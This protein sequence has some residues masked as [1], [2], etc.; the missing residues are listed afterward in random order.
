[1]IAGIDVSK[2]WID[3]SLDGTPARRFAH[4]PQGLAGLVRHARGAEL[5]AMEA[6]GRYHRAAARALRAAGMPVAVL[7]PAQ[8][9]RYGQALGTRSKTDPGDARL[10]ALFAARNPLR[11]EPEPDPAR[12]RL[13]ALVRTRSRQVRA[14]AGLRGSLRAP[15]LDAYERQAM[16]L[17]L[18]F[19]EAQVRLSEQQIRAHLRANEALEGQARLLRTVPGVGE[20]TAWCVLAEFEAARFA[21]AKAA[22]AFAG[23]CPRERRSGSSVRSRSRL[24]KQGNSALRAALYMAALS[25]QSKEPFAALAQRLKGEGHCPKSALG[26]VMHK[27]MRV[28]YGVLKHQKGFTPTP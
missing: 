15:E 14:L 21:S 17:E 5:A 23:V 26:A 24:S 3:I 6:T 8:V 27:L 1:M 12:V 4:T 18:A 7:N 25:A 19:Y 13:T 28:I 11:A 16:Q 9:A 20:V 10:I 22:A 2:D